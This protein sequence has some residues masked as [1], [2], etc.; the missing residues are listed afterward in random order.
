[1]IYFITNQLRIFDTFGIKC[2]TSLDFLFETFKG[3]EKVAV[4]TETTGFDCHDNKLLSLQIGDLNNQFVIDVSVVDITILK[5][6]LESKTLLFQNA[7]FDLRFLFKYGIFPTKILDTYLQE[8]VLNMGR[9]NVRKSLDALAQRY[10]KISLSKEIRGQIHK[11]GL[12]DR[13]IKYAAADVKWLDAINLKQW[14]RLYEAQLDLAA[15]LE[16]TFVVA[17]AY[18]EYCGIHLNK[19]E[20][21]KKMTKDNKNL[22]NSKQKLDNWILQNLSNSK[23]IEPQLDLFSS[24]RSISINWNSPKQVIELF[25][26]LGI[27]TVTKDK[28]TG[29]FKD[30]VEEG[31]LQHQVNDFDILEP[32]LEFKGYSKVVSTY[33]QNFLDQI[34]QYTGR[35]HTS[36]QQL[37]DTGRLSSGDKSTG[38]INLQ[39]I[40]ADKETRNCFT[41][42]YPH[43]ILVNADYSAQEQVIL[44]N[45]A[46]EKNLIDFYRR[47]EGDIHS[48]VAKGIYEELKK[49]SLKEIKEH[50]PE[51]RQVAKSAG[52]A[53][54]YGGTGITIA[55]NVN[56]PIE[57]GEAVYNAYFEAFP[58]LKKDFEAAQRAALS[59]GY[60]LINPI[61]KRKSYIPFFEDFKALEKKINSKGFW[62]IYRDQKARDTKQFREILKPLVKKYFKNKNTI[63]KKALNYRIQGSAAEVTKIACIYFMNWIFDK[64]YQDIVLISNIVHDEILI[65]CPRN[66][67]KEVAENLKKSMELAGDIYCKIIPLKAT[68]IISETW[69]H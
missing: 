11:E 33:G 35:I 45:F 53:I 57:Q 4:D 41:N 17:L 28:K 49:L 24:E 64:K 22:E 15:R 67:A 26:S 18:T 59:V 63:E 19:D 34:N 25:K 5:E 29:E 27:D 66:I 62:N 13:V 20:W 48:F 54:N 6:F 21:Q 69:Q 14:P 31:V 56:I 38:S 65:E 55:Q 23:W 30:S 52:F 39:N 51:K 68:P 61:T 60:I 9:K 37:M 46:K 36:F 58:D 10:L 40:P 44:A 47:G 12:S 3:V 43:T 1:M 16:N 2:L 50:H 32:Y 42:Q 8:S 7:K